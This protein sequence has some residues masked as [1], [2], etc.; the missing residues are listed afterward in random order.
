MVIGLDTDRPALYLS[1]SNTFPGHFEILEQLGVTWDEAF[2][3]R[4]YLSYSSATA[5]SIGR[6]GVYRFSLRPRREH[7]DAVDSL[8]VVERV[9][10]LLAASMPVIDNDLAYAIA[11]AWLPDLQSDLDSYTASRVNLVFDSELLVEPSFIPLNP[12]EG[13]GLLRRMGPGERPGPRDIVIYQ[14]LPNELPRVAGILST[15]PQTPLSHVNL[16]ATQ[17]SIPNAYIR[18]ALGNTTITGLLGD[19]VYYRVTEDAWQIRA[20][21]LAEVNAHYDESRPAQPQRLRRILS[22]TT[23]QPLSDIGFNACEAYGVKAAN[24]AVLGTLG[25][26]AGT[27]PGGF[28]IPFYFYDQFMNQPLGERT[29]FG[30]KSWPAGDK[31]TLGADTKLVEA[32]DA[33]LAHPRFQADPEIQVEMLDDLRDAI[34]DAASPQWII[35]ALTAM[36][37]TYPVGQSL[38]YRSS[39]NNEDLPGF[40]GAGLYDSNT[41]KPSETEE[42]GIDKSLKQVYASLWNYRAFAE[43]EFNRVDHRTVAMGVLVHPNYKEE[44]VNGVAVSVDPLYGFADSYYVNSQVGEDLVTNPEAESLPEE[45]ALHDDGTYTVLATSSLATAGKLLMTSTQLSQLRTHLAQIHT[46][47]T[48]LYNPAAGEPFAM[49]IEFKITSN[50][51]LAIKQAR[52]WIFSS[53]PSGVTTGDPSVRRLTARFVNAPATHDGSSFEVDILYSDPIKNSYTEFYGHGLQVTGGRLTGAEWR[54][55]GGDRWKLRILPSGNSDVT[56]VQVPNRPCNVLGGI[57]SRDGVR[58]STRLELV[59]RGSEGGS[60]TTDPVEGVRTPCTGPNV[61]PQPTDDFV[62]ATEDEDIMID[63]LVNDTDPNSHALSVT[64]YTQPGKGSVTITVDGTA[65]Y[66]PDENVHGPDSFTYA[67]SDG[68]HSATGTVSITIL[69]QNDD[70][71]FPPGPITREVA[72]T[73]TDGD[74]VG[75][76][77]VAVDVDSSNLSYQLLLAAE[78]EIHPQTGQITVL[79]GVTLDP[80]ITP[81]VRRHGPRV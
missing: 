49:E 74:A 23:I 50:N 18:G 66:T 81:V 17:D 32:V 53:P 37:D 42:D 63:V 79:P 67:A 13:Y 43:R 64:E 4:G 11:T 15:V 80:S 55:A 46:H 30:K 61:A 60:G 6:P 29:L 24:V 35:D 54:G 78:F 45:I 27:V 5:A 21:T 16:R 68:E 76:P 1:D 41:Q 8:E 12:G 19:P 22:Q 72:R 52:P 70:P 10:A 56:I 26:V 36:H 73:A 20:A 75:A 14:S 2:H 25:F 9:Y 44:L 47:F 31:L 59:V 40:N 28:A 62:D 39:T 3:M 34:E 48:S 51:V 77:V 65:R 58:L 7:G 57:C 33:I 71:Q 69:P 38:R